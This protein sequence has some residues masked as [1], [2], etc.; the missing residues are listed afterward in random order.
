MLQKKVRTSL[1]KRQMSKAVV[2]EATGHVA[3]YDKTGRI[4]LNEA[5]EKEKTFKGFHSS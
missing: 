1:S 3:F 2:D 4:L 5:K